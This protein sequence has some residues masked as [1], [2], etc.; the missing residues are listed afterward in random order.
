MTA[1]TILAPRDVNAVEGYLASVVRQLL[2]REVSQIH[3]AVVS[4]GFGGEMLVVAHKVALRSRD[5]P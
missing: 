5:G 1:P 4:S 3:T 2:I